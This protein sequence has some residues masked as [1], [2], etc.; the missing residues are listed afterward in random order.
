M[1]I[2]SPGTERTWFTLIYPITSKNSKSVI[3]VALSSVLL[4]AGLASH[5]KASPTGRSTVDLDQATITQ[6]VG[7]SP[8][9]PKGLVKPKVTPPTPII[10]QFTPEEFDAWAVNVSSTVTARSAG[11]IAHEKRIIGTDERYYQSSSA[12]PFGS[13]GRLYMPVTGGYAWCT[14]TLVGPRLMASA[15]H[16]IDSDAQ[17]FLFEPGY[18]NGDVFPS[19]Y[20]TEIVSLAADS[21][22][23]TCDLK[24]DWALYVLGDALGTQRGYMPVGNYTA[25]RSVVENQNVL[26]NAGYP[27][28]LSS[29]QQLYMSDSR[30]SYLYLSGSCAN[31]GPIVGNCDVAGGMSGGPLWRRSG[32]DRWTYGGLYGTAVDATG[33]QVSIHSWGDSFI[34]GVKNLNAQYPS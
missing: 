26:Y 24:N 16:C 29:G 32:D 10:R 22:I 9:L 7:Y 27:G 6:A 12:Y 15:R 21:S 33:T 17:Y 14:G 25:D 30:D 4:V 2:P 19:A 5:A 8:S 3:M 31:G 23:G 1:C 34:E 18:N 28:D 13:I 20:V 11:K